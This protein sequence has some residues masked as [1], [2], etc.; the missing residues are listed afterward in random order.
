[1]YLTVGEIS[2][3][4]GI[5]TEA[6]R[7]YV[8]EGIITPR[9]NQENQYWEYSSDD[10]MKLT[11]IMFYRSMGL[12]MKDIKQIMLGSS[13][14]EIAGVMDVRKQELLKEIKK[15]VDYLNE[16]AVWE[17]EYKREVSLL[18]RFEIGSMPAEFRRQGCMEEANH[19]VRYL[20]ECFDLDKEDWGAVSISFYYDLRDTQPKLQR[21]LSI[22]GSQKLKPSNFA[23]NAIEERAEYCLITEVHYSDDVHDMIDPLL[24]YAEKNSIRLTGAFYG[25]EDTNYFVNGER[26]GLYKVYAPILKK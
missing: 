4:L 24:A 23:E 16:L 3:A 19:M 15:N 21:Y 17:S 5:S 18:N 1:M 8:K 20:K 13:L 6:I 26:K 14:E 7:Y 11:D 22:A 9:R 25:R 10:L 12:T 2:K